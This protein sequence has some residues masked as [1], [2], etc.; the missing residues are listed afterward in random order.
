MKKSIILALTILII[1]ST[2]Q[3]TQAQYS[4]GKGTLADPCQISTTNDWLTPK[5]G[6]IISS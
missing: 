2:H 3:T 5:T 4:G 1:L 6:T